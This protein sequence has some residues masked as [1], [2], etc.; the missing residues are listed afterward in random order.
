MNLETKLGMYFIV[1]CTL[2]LVG[3]SIMLYPT[4]LEPLI[5]IPVK[6]GGLILFGIGGK[7]FNKHFR[8]NE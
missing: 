1:S 7:I 8:I 4:G 2:I 5:E 3:I 6:T